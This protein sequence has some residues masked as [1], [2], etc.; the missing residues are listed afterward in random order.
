MNA[1]FACGFKKVLMYLS[2]PETY[3]LVSPSPSPFLLF[4]PLSPLSLSPLSPVVFADP[5]VFGTTLKFLL[6]HGDRPNR[7]VPS[8]PRALL[9]PTGVFRLRRPSL[10]ASPELQRLLPSSGRQVEEGTLP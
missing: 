2:F 9:G 1:F 7:S 5:D 6:A 3:R 8:L 10:A 4:S